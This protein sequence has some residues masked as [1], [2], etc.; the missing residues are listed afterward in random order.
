MKTKVSSPKIFRDDLSSLFKAYKWQIV[1]VTILSGFLL[2]LLHILMGVSF[3]G[4]SL[5][6]GLKNKLGMY[7]YIKDKPEEED[8][9]YKQVMTLKEQLEQ[10]DIKATFS[11]KEDSVKFLEKR[12]PNLTGTFEKFWIK[13]PLPATLYV[14]LKDK[15][16]YEVLQKIMIDNKSIILNIQDISQLKNLSS[17]ENRILNII[18]LSNFVQILCWIF[19]GVVMRVILSFVI[20]FLKGLFNTFK[21]DIQ[22]KKLL[23]ASS[24][25]IIQPFIWTILFSLI[26]GFLISLIFTWG[27]FRV[28]DYYMSQVFTLTLIPY[29]LE[30]RINVA[31]LLGIE[32]CTFLILSMTIW[33][34][35]VHRLHKKLK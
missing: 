32:L 12:L 19:I 15:D 16:Q 18:K 4:N 22:V 5:N 23:W 2:F 8:Y 7:F 26:I 3:Y 1:R 31:I 28:F 9:I 6:E 35:Y 20:F 34:R 27:S 24:S 33:Y 21:K 13:N 14:T 30:H 11:S 29:L 10:A 17:Q 25:Q